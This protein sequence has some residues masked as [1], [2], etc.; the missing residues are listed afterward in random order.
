MS[1]QHSHSDDRLTPTRR[2][3]M[4][5]VFGSMVACITSMMYA[6]HRSVIVLTP[7]RATAGVAATASTDR[8]A[9]AFELCQSVAST[10][11]RGT[12][13]CFIEVSAYGAAL[14][15]SCCTS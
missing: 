9:A 6:H 5:M 4:P 15:C 3:Q 1:R 10:A 11:A 2:A 13:A 7:R 12:T 8:G 14:V